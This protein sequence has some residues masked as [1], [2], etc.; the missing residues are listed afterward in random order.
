VVLR[1][2]RW[3]RPFELFERLIGMPRATDADPSVILAVMT[4]LMFG[5]MF[6]DVGQGAVL[7]V[8][9]L[10]LQ[11]RF[12]A[13]A[14]LIPAGFAAMVF[15]V[16]F[17]SVFAR[18]DLIEALWLRPLARPLAPLAVSLIFGACMLLLGLVL[19]ALQHAWA[20]QGRLWWRTRAGLMLAY[21]G[22]LGC[23]LTLRS[24]WVVL[25]GL[26]WFWVGSSAGPG[27]RLGRLARSIGASLEALLQLFV[28]T[29][30]FVRIGAFALAHA[31]LASAVGALAAGVHSWALFLIVLAVGNL[32]II[33]IEAL[34]VG[35]QTTRLV[36]FEFFVRFLS[37]GGRP[38]VP[39]PPPTLAAVRPVGT[40]GPRQ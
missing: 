32:A 11:R 8:A 37:A 38:F 12:P 31:G 5:F 13:L 28:N 17:G 34:I 19:D 20:G 39:L 27:D 4:P 30:S 26:V 3:V 36:L 21:L 6:G 10:L 9:G 1:N 33:A 14:L 7:L 16:L 15:G 40:P 2:P 29:L 22:M 24:L 18:D 35:I 25:T 23:A